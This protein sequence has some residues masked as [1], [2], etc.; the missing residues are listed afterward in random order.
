M[1]LGRPMLSGDE[2]PPCGHRGPRRRRLW[3]GADV[4]GVSRGG[5][6]RCPAVSHL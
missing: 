2:V 5:R 1:R 4:F 3:T 6:H